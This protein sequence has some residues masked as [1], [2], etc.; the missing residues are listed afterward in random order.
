M[1]KAGESFG[2]HA[3]MNGSSIGSTVVSKTE[4]KLWV[5]LKDT[6]FKKF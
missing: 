5:F 4:C 1:I 3:L 6:F 2:E